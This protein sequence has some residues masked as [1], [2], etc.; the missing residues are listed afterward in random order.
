MVVYESLVE[1][2]ILLVVLAAM[3]I[4]TSLLTTVIYSLFIFIFSRGGSK[5]IVKL[6]EKY[7]TSIKAIFY[8]T[9]LFMGALFIFSYFKFTFADALLGQMLLFV[10]KAFVA[11]L[12]LYA[13]YISYALANAFVKSSSE[14][15]IG[16]GIIPTVSGQAIG[17][18]ILAV[19]ATI[20]LDIIGLD[21][22]I[23]KIFLVACLLV[24][25]IPLTVLL[26]TIG[27]F[28]GSNLGVGYYI[29]LVGLKEGK[30]VKF[31]DIIGTVDKIAPTHLRIR[32]KKG[33]R[34]IS[35]LE[36]MRDGWE[37]L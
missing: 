35:S 12:V 6:M 15:L 9:F 26:G 13:G 30:K 16:P 37:E 33:V 10:P 21:A 7:R 31:K 27:W 17:I 3:L 2:I 36:F 8:G 11:I 20:S 29:S 19:F 22:E 14:N 4:F 1:V 23:I 5:G 32:T 25:A 28:F 34:V 18:I 24:I